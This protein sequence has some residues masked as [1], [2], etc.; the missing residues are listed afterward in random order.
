ML[1]VAPM[2]GA[3]KNERGPA[4]VYWGNVTAIEF[5]AVCAWSLESK[6]KVKVGIIFGSLD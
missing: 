4:G 5:I 1:I 2:G 6:W 3:A